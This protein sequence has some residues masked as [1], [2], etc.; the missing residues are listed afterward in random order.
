MRR[1]STIERSP[2]LN[3]AFSAS[4]S[5]PWWLRNAHA[6][7]LYGALFTPRMAFHWQHERWE[8]PDQDHLDICRLP[9]NAQAPVLLLLHGLEG[10]AD[11]RYIRQAAAMAH[12]R[13]WS[14]IAPY[15][16]GCG[17]NFNQA[18]RLYHAGDSGELQW[19]LERIRLEF[20]AVPRYAMGFSLGA[21][22]LLKWLGEQAHEAPRWLT[23]CAAI[24][25]PFDLV[26]VGDHLAQGFNRLYTKNFL[27]TLKAKAR[28]KAH[29]YP[30]LFDLK[31]TLTATTLRQFDDHC[32]AP[33]HG[34]VDA[35]DYWTRSSCRPWLCSIRCP[36]LLLQAADDPFIPANALP[37]PTELSPALT[38]DLQPQGGH[39]GFVGGQHQPLWMARH[40]LTYLASTTSRDSQDV[41]E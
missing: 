22:L 9:G 33:L 18:A 8:T 35:Q 34:F 13:G 11:S 6:Q 14:V 27:V 31:R 26:L 32:I 40:V 19:I 39:V 16:R 23:R 38:W 28:A 29:Q 3:P 41:A 12:S 4:F 10:G 15:L 7:T 21:N 30:G 17:P 5:P 36:T 2:P 1:A 24:A 37:R 25:T 20:A